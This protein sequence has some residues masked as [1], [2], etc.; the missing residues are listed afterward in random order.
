MYTKYN[1][2]SYKSTIKI[3]YSY[4]SMYTKYNYTYTS[5]IFLR[6]CFFLYCTLI[7]KNI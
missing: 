6:V 2:N 3:P 5:T 4:V 1:Y 7:H